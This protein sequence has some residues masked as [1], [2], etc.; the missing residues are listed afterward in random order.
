MRGILA[1]FSEWRLS[2]DAL[3]FDHGMSVD[4]IKGSYAMDHSNT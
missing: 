4:Q 1:I 3:N 2:I